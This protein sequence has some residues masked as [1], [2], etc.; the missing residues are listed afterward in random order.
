MALVTFLGYLGIGASGQRVLAG[1]IPISDP[2]TPALQLAFFVGLIALALTLGG[3]VPSVLWLL[4]RQQLCF[5]RLLVFG[6]IIGNVPFALIVI[7]A[8][9]VE[10][11]V[12][13]SVA[14]LWY[15]IAGALRFVL[16]GT[17][18]GAVAA[19]VFWLIVV[20]GRERIGASS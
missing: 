1:G 8:A 7:V 3:A 15:G 19:A 12:S 10:G 9:V 18:H 13:P 2:I 4:R 20:R 14:R 17:V 6:V 5:S 11:T 16:I